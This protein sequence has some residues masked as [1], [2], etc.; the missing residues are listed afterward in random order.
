MSDD[1]ER[2]VNYVLDKDRQTLQFDV[3][4]VKGRRGSWRPKF[5][6]IAP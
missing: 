2:P 6:R 3:T 5:S 4:F 1:L